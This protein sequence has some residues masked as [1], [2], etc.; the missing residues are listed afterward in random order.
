MIKPYPSNHI[1]F[2][3]IS[4]CYLINKYVWLFINKVILTKSISK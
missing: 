1:L 2:D 3:I 4:K